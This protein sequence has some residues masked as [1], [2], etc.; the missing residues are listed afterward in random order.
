V[1]VTCIAGFFVLLK[2]SKSL[3][4]LLKDIQALP[5]VGGTAPPTKLPK[6][7]Y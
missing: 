4:K 1:A 3:K 6:V 5:P 2:L 7:A